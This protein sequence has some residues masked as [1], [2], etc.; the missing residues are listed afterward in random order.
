VLTTDE[1]A[2]RL[3]VAQMAARQAGDVLLGHYRNRGALAVEQKS[4]NDYVSN[5]DREA[6]AV[7]ADLVLGQFPQD[8]FLGEETGISGAAHSSAVWCIDPLDGTTN[9][10]KGAHNWCVSIG[11]FADDRPVLGVIHDPLRDETFVA[12]KGLGAQCNGAPMHVSD[13]S[14]LSRA[15]L[16]LGHNERISVPA[17]AQDVV[18]LLNTGAAFTQVGAAALMLA[19]V[20]DGRVDAYVERHLWPWDAVAGLALIREAGGSTSPYPGVGDLSAGGP[21]I[22]GAPELEAAIASLVQFQF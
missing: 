17:F 4:T 11:L 14:E 13:T 2:A 19:Y 9:F 16:G 5:A 18:V 22:A 7:I 1:L 6:E 8:G 15:T 3:S 10:L 21:V 20:A 12:A